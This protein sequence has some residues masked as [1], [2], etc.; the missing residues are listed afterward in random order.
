M[1]DNSKY[2]TPQMHRKLKKPNVV[3]KNLWKGAKTRVQVFADIQNFAL[4]AH[5]MHGIPFDANY[6]IDIC[7]LL[8]LVESVLS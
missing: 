1:G 4:R 8:P 2:A 6:P 3:Q 5:C 7:I